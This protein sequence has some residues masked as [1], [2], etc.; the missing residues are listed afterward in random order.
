MANG[1]VPRMVQLNL[2]DWSVPHAALEAAF[3]E[4]TKAIIINSPHNPTGKVFAEGD[5]RFIGE[6]C[7]KWG[8]YAILDEARMSAG[9]EGACC[10]PKRAWLTPNVAEG[11]FGERPLLSRNVLPAH[12][13][14]GAPDKCEWHLIGLALGG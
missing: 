9:G 3:S 12:R 7:R 4:R 14:L 8:A 5:L 11:H 13:T 2:S 10:W 6:L 1:G